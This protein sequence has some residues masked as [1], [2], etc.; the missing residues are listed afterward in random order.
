[1]KIN[2]FIGD[3]GDLSSQF[4]YDLFRVYCTSLYGTNI[5]DLSN[6]ESLYVEWRKAVRSIFSL[7]YRTHTQ[8]LSHVINDIP[9]DVCLQQR[10]VNFYYAGLNS[11]NVLVSFMFK[12][13]LCG[14]SRLGSNMKFVLNKIGLLPCM[15]HSYHPKDICYLLLCQWASTCHERNIRDG[16]FVREL[17]LMRDSYGKQFFNNSE[18]RTIIDLIC[19]QDVP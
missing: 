8:L 19:T 6:I 15:V 5:C 1:M 11:E 13:A 14:N 17:I 7:P 4:K 16:L 18:C 3:F 2:G 10:F 9:M 12:N